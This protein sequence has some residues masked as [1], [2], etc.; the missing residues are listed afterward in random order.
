MNKKLIVITAFIISF[1]LSLS[2]YAMSVTYNDETGQVVIGGYRMVEAFSNFVKKEPIN[3]SRKLLIFSNSGDGL[4]LLMDSGIIDYS[5]SSKGYLAVRTSARIR[6]TDGKEERISEIAIYDS[7]RNLIRKIDGVPG[8]SDYKSYAWSPDG[9]KVV[10]IKGKSIML[11]HEPFAQD[12]VW[13]L[14]IKKNETKKISTKGVRVNWADHDNII[15]IQNDF[16]IAGIVDISR[17]DT[18]REILEKSDKKGIRFSGD[19]K[20]Y[21]GY[22]VFSDEEF[23]YFREYVYESTSGKRKFNESEKS[24]WR[25][26]GLSKF[27]FIGDTNYVLTWDLYDYKILDI[28]RISIIRSVKKSRILGWNKEMTKAIVYEG[29]DKIHIDEMITGKRLKTLDLPK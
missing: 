26:Q 25:S 14:D 2:A 3:Y 23:K 21:F 7:D 28:N 27:E 5:L 1:S 11:G 10:F 24:L 29:G 18:K 13:I 15:Y 16:E 20:Y 4:Y 12:G 6:N 22:E 19:G 8:T 17:Y 9:S